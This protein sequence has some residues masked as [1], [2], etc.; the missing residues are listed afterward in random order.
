[1]HQPAMTIE[2]VAHP[3]QILQ[4]GDRHGISSAVQPPKCCICRLNT[5]QPLMSQVQGKLSRAPYCGSIA[6]SP[7][8]PDCGAHDVSLAIHV[9][10]VLRTVM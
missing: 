4:Q 3:L 7:T 1:M 10:E 2:E 5:R 8:L 6:N 9:H